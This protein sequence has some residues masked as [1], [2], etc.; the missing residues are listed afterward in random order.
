MYTLEECA[1]VYVGPFRPFLFAHGLPAAFIARNRRSSDSSWL[2]LYC[3]GPSRGAPRRGRDGARRPPV[4]G[5]LRRRE[6]HSLL[7]AAPFRRVTEYFEALHIASALIK[8]PDQ[9]FLL[10]VIQVDINFV[11]MGGP[12]GPGRGRRGPPNRRD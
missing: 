6:R 9:P 2:V 7:A 4:T 1:L 5:T 3:P 12:G 8:W 10:F 11:D